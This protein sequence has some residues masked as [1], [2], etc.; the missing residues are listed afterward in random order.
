MKLQTNVT[1]LLS[2]V[3]FSLPSAAGG[4]LPFYTEL[5]V[6]SGFRGMGGVPFARSDEVGTDHAVVGLPVV[7]A[8]A[9]FGLS[10]IGLVADWSHGLTSG[11]ERFDLGLELQFRVPL[12]WTLLVFRAGGGGTYYEMPLEVLPETASKATY[13]LGLQAYTSVEARLEIYDG[14]Y[15]GA[16]LRLGLQSGSLGLGFDG[17]AC[18]T[19]SFAVDR[20]AVR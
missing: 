13:E 17:S 19:L 10:L 5:E 9:H 3:L 12:R 7:E 18:A 20:T 14:F 16:L 1:A 4:R 15:L 8:R 6:A 2:V 11:F